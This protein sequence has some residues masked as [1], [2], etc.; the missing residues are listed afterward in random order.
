MTGATKASITI[1]ASEAVNQLNEIIEQLK[2]FEGLPD[3]IIK[4]LLSRG[5][6][7]FDYVVFTDGSSALSATDINEVIIKVKIVGTTDQ[8]TA[9]IRAGNF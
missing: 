6:S 4:L 7:L 9:A 2:P 1:D 5:S 3:H 8:L